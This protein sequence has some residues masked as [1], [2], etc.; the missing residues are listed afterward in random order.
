MTAKSFNTLLDEI[1]EALKTSLK[2]VISVMNIAGV[3][4]GRS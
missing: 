3:D 2:P 1:T 4:S